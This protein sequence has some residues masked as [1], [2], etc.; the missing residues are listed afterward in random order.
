MFLYGYKMLD[1]CSHCVA[2]DSVKRGTVSHYVTMKEVELCM[3]YQHV[4]KST[5]Q[6]RLKLSF[7]WLAS[8]YFSI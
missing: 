8:L 7:L 6:D 2:I 3:T 4:G 5:L 1:I